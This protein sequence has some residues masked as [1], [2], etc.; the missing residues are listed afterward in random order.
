MR[1]RASVMFVSEE[2]PSAPD[3]SLNFV[4]DQDGPVFCRKPRGLREVSICERPA[5]LP[6]NGFNNEGRKLARLQRAFKCMKIVE[7]N[8]LRGTKVAKWLPKSLIPIRGKSSQRHAVVCVIAVQH[9][10]APCR[11]TCKFECALNSFRTRIRKDSMLK[12]ASCAFGKAPREEARECR[13]I[14]LNPVGVAALERLAE[15]VHHARV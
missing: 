3:A 11:S 15:R 1:A 2:L 13:A 14:E 12:F 6:L 7:G 10:V 9:G 8:L 5:G 4:D